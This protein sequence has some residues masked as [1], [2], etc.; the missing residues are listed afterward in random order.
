[1][2]YHRVP[3]YAGPWFAINVL[4]FALACGGKPK[5]LAN[6]A[7]SNKVKKTYLEENNFV[8]WRCG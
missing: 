6:P 4:G 1:M 7:L 8:V 2:K 5:H 3:R